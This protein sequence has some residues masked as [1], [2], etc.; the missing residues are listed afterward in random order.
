VLLHGG[1]E[2]GEVGGSENGVVIH[3]EEVGKRGKLLQ[4]MLACES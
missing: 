2:G 3:D 4:G 1:D